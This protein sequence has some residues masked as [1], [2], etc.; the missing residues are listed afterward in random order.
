MPYNKF[1]LRKVIEDFSLQIVEGETFIPI[2]EP[3]TPSALLQETLVD[4]L[5]WAIAV[6]SEKARSEA[7]ISPILLEVRRQMN[8]QV[9]VFSGEDFTVDVE[10]ELSGRCDFLV[11]KSAE[12][13]FIKAPA[14]ILVEAKKEDTKP[15]LGQCLAEMLAAQRF[16]AAAKTEIPVIYGCVTSGTAW[17]FLKLEGQVVTIDLMDY[18]LSPVERVLS[19]FLWMLRSD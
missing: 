2:L 13:L 11:S 3:V 19:I 17:R 14:V 5:P 6:G 16:N 8:R 7:I 1:T 4:N 10:A 9:S 15:G 12:Q 18:P